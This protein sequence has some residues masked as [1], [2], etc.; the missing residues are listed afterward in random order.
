MRDTESS[1]TI[2]RDMTLD[3]LIALFEGDGLTVSERNEDGSVYMS[4]Q[5]GRG[6]IV[7]TRNFGVTLIIGAG[8]WGKGGDVDEAKREFRRAGGRLS[9]GYSVVTFPADTL[10]LGVDGMGSYHWLGEQP[11]SEQHKRRG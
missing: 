4:S 8:Y 10:F 6:Y 3:E 7:A 11:T 2:H 1:T 9:D 5:W